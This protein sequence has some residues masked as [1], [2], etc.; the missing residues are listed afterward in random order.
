MELR[1]TY[2]KDAN[3]R[4]VG[5]LINYPDYLRQ[6]IDL[7]ELK[8]KL[9]DLQLTLQAHRSWEAEGGSIFRKGA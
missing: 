1:I 5:S 4:Y 9:I 3:G 2:W 8:S 7:E 6:G